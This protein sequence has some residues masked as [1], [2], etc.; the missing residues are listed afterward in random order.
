MCQNDWAYN[1]ALTTMPLRDSSFRIIMI[2]CRGHSSR[3]K[4]RLWQNQRQRSN[5]RMHRTCTKDWTKF[6][7]PNQVRIKWHEREVRVPWPQFFALIFFCSIPG[8][9]CSLLPFWWRDWWVCGSQRVVAAAT[10][11]QQ[12]RTFGV[13]IN[14]DHKWFQYPNLCA[15]LDDAP[16]KIPGAWTRAWASR[17]SQ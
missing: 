15:A 14:T 7:F 13:A 2:W 12:T 8:A 6:P 10:K 3:D 5:P 17:S 11:Q 4:I 16:A 9:H 1:W